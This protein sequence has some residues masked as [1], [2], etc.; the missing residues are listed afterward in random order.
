MDSSAMRKRAEWLEA[1]ARRLDP[2]VG[3]PLNHY[4]AR[5]A[6]IAND[7]DASARRERWERH[8]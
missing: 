2:D 4:A 8:A 3:E 7:I 1:V 5:L 6:Q